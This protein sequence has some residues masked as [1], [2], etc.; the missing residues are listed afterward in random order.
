[1]TY[2]KMDNDT[3][4]RI[5]VDLVFGVAALSD[6]ATCGTWYIKVCIIH[7]DMFIFIIHRPQYISKQ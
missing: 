1:M 2:I 3:W 5:N 4:L 6:A 7:V